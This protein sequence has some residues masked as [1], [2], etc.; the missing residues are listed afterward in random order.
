MVVLQDFGY[1]QVFF[2]Y[3]DMCLNCMIKREE[4]KV[5]LFDVDDFVNFLGDFFFVVVKFE[6]VL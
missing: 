1:S 4:R 6:L 2:N 5:C 3:F